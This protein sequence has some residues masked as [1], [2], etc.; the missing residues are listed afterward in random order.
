MVGITP[1]NQYEQSY[2]DMH[3]YKISLYEGVLQI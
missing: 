1:G 2:Y 3:Q